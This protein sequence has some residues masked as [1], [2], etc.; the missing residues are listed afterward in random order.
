[1]WILWILV[2]DTNDPYNGSILKLK[3]DIFM[4]S[5]IW[6]VESVNGKTPNC[7]DWYYEDELENLNYI[8]VQEKHLKLLVFL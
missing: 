8:I 5:T 2:T 7:V 3:K 1:M 6:S 4:R